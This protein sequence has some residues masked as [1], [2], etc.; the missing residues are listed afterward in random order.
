MWSAANAPGAGGRIGA[1]AQQVSER[2][3][4][5]TAAPQ[6]RNRRVFVV[7]AV[8]HGFAP[9]ER[10]TECILGEIEREGECSSG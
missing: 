5:A 2:S 9:P 8:R 6:F 3:A 1:E 4:D 10:L 7:W